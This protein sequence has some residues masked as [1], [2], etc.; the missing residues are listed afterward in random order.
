MSIT[1]QDSAQ[2]TSTVEDAHGHTWQH[3]AQKATWTRTVGSRELVITH[4][5][6]AAQPFGLEI[7]VRGYC[8]QDDQFDGFEAAAG[9]AHAMTN[10]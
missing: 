6:L 7:R 9:M 10:R 2:Q 3:N 5:D 4:R 1:S 8:I